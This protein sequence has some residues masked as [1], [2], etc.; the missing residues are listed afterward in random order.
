MIEDID[1]SLDVSGK[2]GKKKESEIRDSDPIIKKAE[3]EGR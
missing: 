2:R 3:S 1:C